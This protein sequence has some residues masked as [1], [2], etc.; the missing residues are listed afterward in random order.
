MHIITCQDVEMKVR[1]QRCGA[2]LLKDSIVER[3]LAA[4]ESPAFIHESV[5]TCLT[6]LTQDRDLHRMNANTASATVEF[7]KELIRRLERKIARLTPKKPA[8]RPAKRRKSTPPRRRPA[9][10][11][12][13]K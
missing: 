13:N 12:R 6:N 9:R 1:C 3:L 2:G 5:T 4:S 7:L 10:I 8:K 11:R